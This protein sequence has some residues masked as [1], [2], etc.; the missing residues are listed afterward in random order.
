MKKIEF[1]QPEDWFHRGHDFAGGGKNLDG[2]WIPKF[3]K[4]VFI[5]TPP[6]AA[7]LA[8]VEQ[9]REA[10]NKRMESVHIVIIPRL[11]TSLWRRQLMRAS[12]VFCE[13][14]FD[15]EFWDKSEQH[16]PLTLTLIFPFLP[17]SPWQL[18]RSKA[19]LE[20]GRVLQAMWKNGQIAAGPI[21]CEL[22]SRTRD[23]ETMPRGVV[24]KMLQTPLRF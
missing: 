12:D 2:V 4:G 9:L 10:R 6:P 11:F 15:E 3:K 7:A 18:R 5:W 16:E 17:Y 14:P 1:L 24:S 22:L 23:L 19:F 8:A 13:L 20:M 21:L